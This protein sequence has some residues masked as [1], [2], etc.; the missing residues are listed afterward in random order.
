MGKKNTII[1]EFMV[2][3]P[4]EVFVFLMPISLHIDYED[5]AN[6]QF[7]VVVQNLSTKEVFIEKISP[8]IF[9]T[10]FAFRKTYLQKLKG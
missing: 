7:N 10:H 3:K 6:S 2:K 4:N 8:E 5:L 1:P 9:F